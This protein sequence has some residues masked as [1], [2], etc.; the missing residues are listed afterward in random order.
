[1]LRQGLDEIGFIK[2]VKAFHENTPVCFNL[3]VD[4]VLTARSCH[5]IAFRIQHSVCF[6]ISVM[7]KERK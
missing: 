6:D 7:K 2:S 3:S 4:L 5:F 1:M